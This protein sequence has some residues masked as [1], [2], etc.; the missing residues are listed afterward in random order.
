MSSSK[1]TQMSA[2]VTTN[3]ETV[4]SQPT[5]ANTGIHWAASA[6]PSAKLEDLEQRFEA[7]K[8]RNW[9]TERMVEQYMKH[10]HCTREAALERLLAK[11]GA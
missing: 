5:S 8:A 6:A 9:M 2:Q 4:Q 3:S 7:M 1:E 10:W 11:H